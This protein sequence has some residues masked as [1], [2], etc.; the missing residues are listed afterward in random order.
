MLSA[1]VRQMSDAGRRISTVEN[2]RLLAFDWRLLVIACLLLLPSASRA[3]P[4]ALLD[5]VAAE[6]R[7][8]TRIAALPPSATPPVDVQ[9]P[10]FAVAFMLFTPSRPVL[11]A[12]PVPVA[13][14][15]I[16]SATLA[17]PPPPPSDATPAVRSLTV[18]SP[19]LPVMSAIPLANAPLFDA[20]SP[21]VRSLAV[22][23]GTP[24]VSSALRL[25]SPDPPR[26]TVSRPF[27]LSV[28]SPIGGS[29]FAAIVQARL[30]RDGLADGSLTA[31][32]PEWR[33]KLAP[34]LEVEPE[35]AVHVL[36]LMLAS[37]AG[38]TDRA[39]LATAENWARTFEGGRF[40]GAVAHAAARRAF[41][42]GEL[43][44][45]ISRCGSLAADHPAFA[46]RALLLQALARAHGGDFVSALAAL[47]TLRA[48]HPGSPLVPEARFMEAWIAL[49][50]NRPADARAIL[51]ETVTTHR[52]SPAADKASKL[53]ATLED[54]P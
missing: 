33:S 11:L 35:N 16:P 9:S 15:S 50:D 29:S 45:A 48:D 37:C 3:K 41:D 38:A 7:A 31:R 12:A 24:P 43:D 26:A 42:R 52:G 20:A 13:S 21:G 30:V 54:T 17:A 1:A 23:S 36:E 22:V 4:D 46:D 27:R 32:S 18:L 47:A 19:S 5:R 44:N 34:L 53:L 40:S 2:R 49:Q 6:L 28:R 14:Q 10:A 25:A 51:S 39:R 8:A